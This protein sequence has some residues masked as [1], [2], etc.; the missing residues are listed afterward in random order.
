MTGLHHTSLNNFFAIGVNY[1]KTDAAMRSQFA[2]SQEQYNSILMRAAAMECRDLLVLSTCNRTELYGFAPQSVTLIQLLCEATQAD[3]NAFAEHGYIKNGEDAVKHLFAV[4]AGL[5][6]QLLG[7]YEIVGQ[8]KTAVRFAKE[9]GSLGG[10]TERL[11]NCVLQA[12]KQIKNQTHLSGGTVSVSFAAVQ[13][14]RGRIPGNAGKKILLLGTGKIGRT[15]AKNLKDYLGT[16]HITLIN[17]SP[18]KAMELAEQLQLEQCAAEFLPEAL[19]QSDVILVA[20]HAPHPLIDASH[21]NADAEKLIIDLSIPFNVDPSVKNIP[22]ISLV[23][24]DELSQI[25]DETLRRREADIPKAQHIIA[26]HAGEFMDWYQ[27]RQ[28]APILKAAKSTL[29]QIHSDPLFLPLYHYQP[30]NSQTDKKIQRIINGMASKMKTANQKG[31]HFI[32]AIN[33]FIEA[34]TSVQAT[35]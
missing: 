34:G 30:M 25:N 28:H 5:D 6:S 15:V 31:C 21:F 9:H 17:R 16:H 32:Q 13:Y 35:L 33:E 7:D 22:G 14:I 10:F 4:A 24:V 1:R 20:T 26:Q 12:S 3:Q 18:E 2:V 8:L 19:Q 11:I 27:M 29:Q 23:N